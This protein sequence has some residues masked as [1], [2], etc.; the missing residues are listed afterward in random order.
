MPRRPL[1][2]AL[3][4]GAVVGGGTL[5]GRRLG[6]EMGPNLVVRCRRGHLFTTVWF[7]GATVKSLDLVI[8]RLQRCPVG[9]HL[10]LVTPVREREL[11]DAERTAAHAV[12]DLR[13]P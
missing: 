11:S 2:T 6:Y 3:S 7:P 9:G 12:H 4:C 8:A 13:L 10:S 5:I 1:L